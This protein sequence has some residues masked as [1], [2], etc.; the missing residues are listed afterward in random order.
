[1]ARKYGKSWVSR[2]DDDDFVALTSSQQALYDALA[3]HPDISWCGVLPLVPSRFV[4]LASD[5]TEPRVRAL[6]K[7]LD[8]TRFLIVDPRTGEMC[9]RTFIRWDEVLKVPNVTK[10]MGRAFYLV[11]SERIQNA[12]LIELAR[13]LDDFPDL[14]GWGALAA[15]YP[16]L[17]QLVRLTMDGIPSGKGSGNPSPNPSANPSINPSGKGSGNGNG[18][19]SRN[20]PNTLN[21][22]T[23]QP[24]TDN[25]PLAS[26]VGTPDATPAKRAARL[27]AGFIPDEASR[28]KIL[29]DFP[30]IDLRLEHDKFVDYWTAKPGKDGVK[31]DWDATWRNWMRKA[32]Q[33][34]GRRRPQT[35]TDQFAGAIARAEAAEPTIRGELA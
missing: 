6:I 31:L 23:P 19:R 32:G 34:L 3:T 13:D 28:A 15:S 26:L 11:H 27:P 33:D 17:M 4:N 14:A 35:A 5:Y 24:L 20:T 16:E 18:N 25:P 30:D 1:M 7:A 10:A 21:P 12:I 8:R 22:S 29:S 2:W 9:V